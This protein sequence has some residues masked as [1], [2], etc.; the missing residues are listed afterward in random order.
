MTKYVIGCR[1]SKKS[2]FLPI[3]IVNLDHQRFLGYC[4]AMDEAGLFGSEENFLKICPG[5]RG[6]KNNLD[7]LYE[8]SFAYT[9]IICSSDYYAAMLLNTF[10]RQRE[11]DSG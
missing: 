5:N 3:I 8:R 1:S 10:S 11:K 2:R 9:A 7:E 4:Q 6:E